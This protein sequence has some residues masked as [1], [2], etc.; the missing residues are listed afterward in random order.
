M[1]DVDHVQFLRVGKLLRFDEWLE[2]ILLQLPE[3]CR[4]ESAERA[5]DLFA[6]QVCFTKLQQAIQ[7]G[8]RQENSRLESAS[9]VSELDEATILEADH[10]KSQV[11]T[12]LDVDE[13]V[14]QG[15]S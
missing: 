14:S 8:I 10:I 12:E 11:L 6:Q 4:S 1:V 3:D 13:I 15:F 7:Q 9:L 5:K 2:G